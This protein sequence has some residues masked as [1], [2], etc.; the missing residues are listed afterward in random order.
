M[1]SDS[2]FRPLIEMTGATDRRQDNVE[3]DQ[4]TERQ[5]LFA[6]V[7]TQ[8]IQFPRPRYMF[9]PKPVKVWA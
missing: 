7:F 3:S 8:I 4:G 1:F 9:T 6:N 2:R 5:R